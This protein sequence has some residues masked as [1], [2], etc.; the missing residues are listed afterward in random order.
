MCDLQS[1]IY[2][3]TQSQLHFSNG[4]VLAGLNN[5]E[6]RVRSGDG[7]N[8]ARR[9]K[10]PLPS[11]SISFADARATNETGT[12]EYYVMNLRAV[13]QPSHVSY[14]VSEGGLYNGSEQCGDYWVRES[15][16]PGRVYCREQGT[17]N[18]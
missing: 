6:V 2:L 7:L 17:G 13:P 9:S 14:V 12:V 15:S 5:T 18:S 10:A 1:A 11:Q 3:C 4:S 8:R 16:S